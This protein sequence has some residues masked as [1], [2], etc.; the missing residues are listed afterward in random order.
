MMNADG[1]WEARALLT[2]GDHL[3]SRDPRFV[4]REYQPVGVL[5]GLGAYQLD[6]ETI[7]V[8]VNHELD[9]KAGNPYR[10]DNGTKLTG[11]RI[12]FLDIDRRTLRIVDSGIAYGTIRDRQDRIVEKGFQINEV[13][14]TGQGLSRLCSSQLIEKDTFNFVDTIFMTQEELS[15]PLGHPY[16]GTVWAL[17]VERQ[18]LHAVP[19]MGRMA[20]ENTTP[21]SGP[22][23]A[24]AFLIGDDT[25]PQTVEAEDAGQD[26]GLHTSPGHVVTAPLWLY[27]GKKNAP[28]IEPALPFGIDP[29]NASFLNRNG[30]LAGQL[31]YFAADHGVRTV[32]QFNGTGSTLTGVWKEIDVWDGTKAGEKGYDPLG[33][34]TGLTLRR[35]AKAGG[36]F[37]FSRPEDVS[38]HPA[39]GTRAVLAST[40]R[41]TVFPDHDAWGTIYR[42]DVDFE[43]MTATLKILYDGDDAGGA[44]FSHP[45]QGIRNPDNLEW[46][47]DGWLYIQEDK[48]KQQDP[49]FG[50]HSGEESSL[51]RLD[52]LTGEVQRIARI[53]RSVILPKGSTDEKPG[54]IGAWESSGILD[55]THLFVTRVEE[56][57]LL[58]T[59]QAHTIRDGLIAKHKLDEGG[60][61]I[62]L[63]RPPAGFSGQ[64]GK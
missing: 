37:Q 54:V 50:S 60:Q 61:L 56:R 51:W 12:S 17:D 48:A 24:V 15:D 25:I 32:A 41:D 6:Q 34:K 30:L 44:R 21:L 35:E 29:G 59:V 64:A 63:R 4:N 53:D 52:P 20:G 18:T 57:V 22:R 47:E 58:A 2:I 55:V 49:L 28:V 38:T 39:I 5:D 11:A 45:D 7:R 8:L 36:A 42:I 27:V 40:G 26:A 43:A 19:A 46:G 23:D 3:P 9:G 10:L 13:A 1:A 62:L 31:Y 33:Y 16:G 14:Q